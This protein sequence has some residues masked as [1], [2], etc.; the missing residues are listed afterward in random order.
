MRFQRSAEEGGGAGDPPVA[1]VFLER[2][3]LLVF[4]GPAY[5]M[6]HSIPAVT[7][8]PLGPPE[9][10]VNLARVGLDDRAAPER[11]RRISVTLRRVRDPSQR[12]MLGVLR[13]IP[14]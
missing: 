10:V 4:R 12:W 13:V 7:C 8:D 6:L 9:P 1:S 14:Y 2:R 5:R 11:G 3:S